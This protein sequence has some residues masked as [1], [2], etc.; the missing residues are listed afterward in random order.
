[1]AT[2]TAYATTDS[3]DLG[4]G[5]NLTVT[6]GG[7][8]VFLLDSDDQIALQVYLDTA[9]RLPTSDSEMRMLLG[10]RTDGESKK[11]ADLIQVYGQIFSRCL[12]FKNNIYPESVNLAWL[13]A[14]YAQKSFTYY[15]RITEAFQEFADGSRSETSVKEVVNDYVNILRK[16]IDWHISAAE[17]VHTAFQTFDTGT[18][19]DQ[20]RIELTANFYSD[21]FNLNEEIIK[22]KQSR[23]DALKGEI[24]AL[25]AE[26]DQAVIIASTTPTYAWIPFVGWIVGP[27]VAGIY[28]AK[29]VELEKKMAVLGDELR[30]TDADLQLR[31]G[32]KASLSLVNDDLVGLKTKCA[33]AL[34]ALA[35]IKTV[36]TNIDAA[37]GRIPAELDDILN[38]ETLRGLQRAVESASLEWAQVYQQAARYLATAFLRIERMIG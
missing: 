18:T 11:F 24:A 14:G 20:G 22:Q 30:T 34:K 4:P 16:D 15:D 13:I 19:A 29:A 33:A 25:K 17:R 36:W 8:Q 37:L 9:T 32:L 3:Q 7:K 12:D 6:V 38:K 23:I 26:Y 21:E 1:M 2:W 28:G 31:I 35:R 27:T 5:S 10:Y